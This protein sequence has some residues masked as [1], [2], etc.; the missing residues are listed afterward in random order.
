MPKKRCCVFTFVKNEKIF[1]PIW[2]KY[3][4]RFF[5]KDD[6]Y[7][8]DHDTDD[9][10]VQECSKHY[11]FK[12]IK[13]HHEHYDEIWRTGVVCQKQ[14]ELLQ[15]YE[16]VLFTDADEII[17]P[18]PGKYKDL[19]DYIIRCSEDCVVCAGHELIHIRQ[20][21]PPIDLNKPILN[22]RKYWYPNYCYDKPL[23]A[24]KPLAWAY[25]FH[26]AVNMGGY[27]DK[28][29]WLFHLH[30]MDFDTCWDKHKRISNYK[31]SDE[32]IRQNLGFQL[33]INNMEDFRRFFDTRCP[34]YKELRIGRWWHFIRLSF[35][36]AGIKSWILKKGSLCDWSEKGL[37][38]VMITKIPRIL[39]KNK[40][41]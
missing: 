16:Y 39:I 17:I 8:L 14:T 10:S 22:Q 23:L 12:V 31:W 37:N 6:I 26:N 5:D 33:R 20:K 35:L 11:G 36:K 18:N 21:E 3:Y 29:L 40:I 34:D 28:D 9:G 41:V 27:R 38:F 25:G 2:L 1:L 7:V 24:R 30:K 32:C 13:L 15:S 4:S 19:K